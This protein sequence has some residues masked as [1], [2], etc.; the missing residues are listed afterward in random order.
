MCE[1][2]F[3]KSHLFDKIESLL[4]SSQVEPVKRMCAFEVGYLKLYYDWIITLTGR[5]RKHHDWKTLLLLTQASEV[6]QYPW[7]ENFSTYS[8]L[9]WV[10]DL[11]T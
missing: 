1:F 7:R 3:I 2:Y 6:N 11:E 5:V 10:R 9:K 8:G 4:R